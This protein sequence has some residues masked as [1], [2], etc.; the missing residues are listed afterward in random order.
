MT[1]VGRQ[2]LAEIRA[3]M[4]GGGSPPPSRAKIAA[5][6]PGPSIFDRI[7]NVGLGGLR[8]V[9]E[10]FEAFDAPTR[11]I[12]ANALELLGREPI[13]RSGRDTFAGAAPSGRELLGLGTGQKGK[14]E[15]FDDVLGFAA[16]VGVSPF[17]LV[18]ALKLSKAGE[19]AQ[20]GSTLAQRA[21][22]L[23]AAG[24]RA[25]AAST[26]KALREVDRQA[27][28]LGITNNRLLPR[29]RDQI[30]GGQRGLLSLDVPFTGINAPLGPASLNAEIAGG[31]ADAVKG[32]ARGAVGLID[33]IPKVGPGIGSFVR[34]TAKLPESI[35]RAAFAPGGKIGN[36]TY[37]GLREIDQELVRQGARE[38]QTAGRE[39][40]AFMRDVDP[41]AALRDLR[42]LKANVDPAVQTAVASIEQRYQT[43]LARAMAAGNQTKVDAI[44]RK[45]ERKTAHLRNF[46]AT[47]R[48][49]TLLM[50]H[51]GLHER[52]A[53]ARAAAEIASIQN[54]AAQ[55]ELQLKAQARS[56]TMLGAP[57]AD[58][59]RIQARLTRLRNRTAQRVLELSAR[60]DVSAAVM[61]ALPP[62]FQQHV[63]RV[64]LL[65]GKALDIEQAAGVRVSE[66]IDP[67][68]SYVPR[69][70]TEEGRLWARQQGRDTPF[71]HFERAYGTSGG[72]TKQRVKAFRGMS[73]TQIN[74]LARAHGFKGE[75]FTENAAEAVM[76]RLTDGG[77]KR[78]AAHFLQGVTELF[79][80]PRT[81]AKADGMSVAEFLEGANITRVGNVLGLPHDKGVIAAKLAGT[82][83]DGA[84]IPNDIAREALKVNRVVETPAALKSLVSFF[85]QV[86]GL[87]R[88][89]AT[90][91]F[92]A[93]HARNE[94]GNWFNM[95]LA[96]M[97]D[98][99]WM[100]RAAQ[101][102][103]KIAKGT[104]TAAERELYNAAVDIGSV[105]STLAAEGRAIGAPGSPVE[106]FTTGI[107]A[108]FF[109]K[110]A[111]PVLGKAS[112]ALNPLKAGAAI[113]DNAKLAMF[114][115][116]KA[117]GLADIEAGRMVRKYLF[118]YADLSHFEKT[119][120]RRGAYFYT[121]TRKAIP[122]LMEQVFT[123]PRA[124]RF[125]GL[126]T[127]QTGSRGEGR[128]NLLP[129]WLADRAPIA[130][131][132]D[133]E[134]NATFVSLGLPLDE[135]SK[136]SPE[137]GGLGTAVRKGLSQ[138]APVPKTLIEMGT[139]NDLR[140]GRALKGIDE[141]DLASNLPEGLRQQT[142]GLFKLLE[143]ASPASRFGSTLRRG[144]ETAGSQEPAANGDFLASLF[145][146]DVRR[147]D[148]RR[149]ELVS[150]IGHARLAL[151]RAERAGMAER[152]K[153]L[154]SVLAKLQRRLPAN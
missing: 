92:L 140:T 90:Q 38:G 143:H 122:L 7:L 88:F 10:T 22:Q 23:K 153:A 144:I 48:D 120:L 44:Q 21:T 76:R 107:A 40:A 149:A 151:Q 77:R 98:P 61:N 71:A 146:A 87:F 85:D 32:A 50:L 114:M 113:E 116:A 96:G 86:H 53:G 29:F 145:G 4:R 70:L 67:L 118:D 108:P 89:G 112:A 127:G 8:T 110:L 43:Q 24:K 154:R 35:Y 15:G 34:G 134:G 133:D 39:L 103:N 125:M 123:N 62:D 41:D 11:A 102:Q 2:I 37:D 141:H 105:T 82:H 84:F 27:A 13:A 74:D 16:E 130:A 69:M 138:L 17:N 95:F 42:S 31:S 135:L 101:L 78:G 56:M 91:F 94:I 12:V 79:H 51:L 30:R 117:K 100:G 72:F 104:A 28:A 36:T 57:R 109:E 55:L 119:W 25:E 93:Y 126:A 75:F 106:R 58:I 139:G 136:F 47:D 147:I 124:M 26:L 68:L 83:L 49:P 73:I 18:S 150:R 132:E 81:M 3:D 64:G 33:R 142:G 115:W 5:L 137:G 66:L 111:K 97:R 63:N 59:G 52:D 6:D 54:E 152:A 19:L 45:I 20:R 128:D 80:V 148:P 14:F 65:L 129:A 46:I 121:Y 131:G 99:R 1:D 60:A 9:G